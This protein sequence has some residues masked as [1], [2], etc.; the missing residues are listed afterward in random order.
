MNTA[1]KIYAGVLNEKLIKAV[2]EKLQ[3]T[4]FGFRKGRGTADAIY[5]LNYII[6]KELS[7][8]RGKVFAFFADLRAAFDRVDRQELN[9][10]MKRI[11]IEDHL[12][13]RVME[14][15]I[16]TKNTVRIGERY[17]EDF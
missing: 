16:E 11:G 3:E 6:N 15:Y 14:T 4:Q 10:R 13:K 2:E 8:K 7:K 9:R 1:Y 5:V 12:R 17:T